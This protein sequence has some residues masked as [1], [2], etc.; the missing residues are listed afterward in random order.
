MIKN[1]EMCLSMLALLAQLVELLQLFVCE[2][3]ACKMTL[4]L[5]TQIAN[6]TKWPTD[7]TSLE[8]RVALIKGCVAKN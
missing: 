1:V 6:M 8:K 2:R 7:I 4:H 3:K 5:M